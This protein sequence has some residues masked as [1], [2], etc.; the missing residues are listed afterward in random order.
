M[1]QPKLSPGIRAQA[2]PTNRR[3]AEDIMA[4]HGIETVYRMGQNENPLGP[5]PRALA[6][7][8][9]AMT[10]IHYYP[11]ASDLALREAL[12]ETHGRGLSPEHF[13]TSC[14]GYEAL[15]MLS[16]AFL[17]DGDECIVS[18]P[19]F[20]AVYGKNAALEDAVIVDVPLQP[21]TFALDVDGILNAITD[22]TRLLMLCNP[23][24]PTGTVFDAATMDRLMQ[25]VPEHVIVVSDEVYHHFV[26]ADDFPDSL[27]YVLAERNLIIVLS[28]S[29]G[30]GLA[31]LR[32]GYGIAKPELASY[33][34]GMHRGFHQNKINLAAGVA[35]LKD[36]DHLRHVID[37]ILTEKAWVLQQLDRL[38][39][40]HWPSETNFVLMRTPLHAQ[41]MA[42][43]LEPYGVMVR[44][45]HAAGLDN[46]IRVTMGTR[47]AN[48]TFIGALEAVLR[49]A[50]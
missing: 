37:T 18:N 2:R 1:T 13:Y 23:N 44:P 35:A 5:S 10:T 48:E 29:K 40:R 4:D 20:S 47:E 11:E 45:Q 24:N 17:K 33:L 7:M 49:E 3:M 34:G 43:K 26:T 27:Q 19:T 31:G 28:F 42:E 6:A 30:Y 9:N 50:Q 25:N 46:C 22:R 39:V 32:M 12:A 21:E 16:R 15:E 41:E 14:S 36:T 8:A 38:D